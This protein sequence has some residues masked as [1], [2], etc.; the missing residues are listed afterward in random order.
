[1]F[2][3]RKYFWYLR[4]CVSVCVCMYVC[5][6]IFSWKMEPEVK[7]QENVFGLIVR[8]ELIFTCIPFSWRRKKYARVTNKDNKYLSQ[9]AFI[10]SEI[11]LRV[12]D[13][14]LLLYFE[15]SFTFREV[16]QKLFIN[17]WENYL[18]RP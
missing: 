3:M 12:K 8:L 7:S 10:N 1:M 11:S 18:F 9:K 6:T 4:V 2:L 16:S 17:F 13:D 15:G 5:E 14:D